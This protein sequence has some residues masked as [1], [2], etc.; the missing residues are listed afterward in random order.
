MPIRLINKS[1]S[2]TKKGPGRVHQS[3]YSRGS[4]KARRR[5]AA[6]TQPSRSF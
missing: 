2:T 1:F 6:A 4:K 3:G 5:A